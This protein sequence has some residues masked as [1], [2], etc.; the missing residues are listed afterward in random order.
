[1][2]KPSHLV[3][4]LVETQNTEVETIW[5]E[6]KARQAGSSPLAYG[7]AEAQNMAL[8]A[9]GDGSRRRLSNGGDG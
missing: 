5:V 8:K 4:G 7:V 6:T 9:L 2:K 1:M 3:K